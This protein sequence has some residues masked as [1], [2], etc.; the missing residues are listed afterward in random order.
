MHLQL[1]CS[2]QIQIY[3]AEP[4]TRGATAVAHWLPPCQPAWACEDFRTS[5]VKGEDKSTHFSRKVTGCEILGGMGSTWAR[6]AWAWRVP[7]S[8]RFPLSL[9]PCVCVLTFTIAAVLASRT[10]DR[11]QLSRRKPWHREH[12]P[13]LIV[14]GHVSGES[15]C[16]QGPTNFPD[17]L[18]SKNRHQHLPRRPPGQSDRVPSR[19]GLILGQRHTSEALASSRLDHRLTPRGHQ[20][21]GTGIV[22][23]TTTFGVPL[24]IQRLRPSFHPDQR[25]VYQSRNDRW[26]VLAVS[27]G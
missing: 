9:R 26:P 14:R 15:W 11:R 21:S 5:Q 22:C 27:N 24:M 7:R 12:L 6:M 13:G 1:Y 18:L 2:S 20:I 10:N 17:S 4:G 19:E 8:P 25:V 3:S 16:S 23:G